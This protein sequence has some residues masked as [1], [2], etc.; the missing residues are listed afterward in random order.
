M[1]RQFVV[2]FSNIRFHEHL[3]CASRVVCE[4]TERCTKD[5]RDF[6][7]RSA[8]ISMGTKRELVI[9]RR[10]QQAWSFCAYEDSADSSEVGEIKVET[11]FDRSWRSGTV[12]NHQQFRKTPSG[13]LLWKLWRIIERCSGQHSTS[14]FWTSQTRFPGKMSARLRFLVVFRRQYYENVLRLPKISFPIRNL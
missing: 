13:K 4:K 3:L 12:L 1:A 7:T 14:I 2:K 8:R 9:I 10:R 6:N 11:D 5:R